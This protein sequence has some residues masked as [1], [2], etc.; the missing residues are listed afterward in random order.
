[1]FRIVLTLFLFRFFIMSSPIIGMF[2]AFMAESGLTPFGMAIVFAS[3]MVA[4]NLFEVPSSV[5]A[6]K[7]SRKMVIIWAIIV[8]MLSNVIFLFNQEQWAFIVH[9]I[10]AG[11]G[12]ALFSGTVEALLYD[13]LKAINKE[14]SYQKAYSFYHIAWSLGL[15]VSLFLSAFLV[16][17][18]YFIIVVWSLFSCFISLFFFIFGIKETKRAKEI[19][20]PHS[21][22]EIFLEGGRT[23]LY[24]KSVLYLG[25]ISL[26]FGAINC[27]FGDVAVI[28]SMEIGWAK[29]TMARIFGFNTIFEAIITFIFAKYAKKISVKSVHCTL[30]FVLLLAFIGMVF[31]QKWS[32]FMVFPL[33]WSD[34][35]KNMVV[36]AQIQNHVKSSSRATVTSCV[37][38]CFGVNY[39][40]TMLFL[41]IIATFYSFSL[42]FVIISFTGILQLILLFR[43]LK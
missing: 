34:R 19:D 21:F 25:L 22:K 43:M 9:M 1:M 3:F 37:S 35:L 20:A 14:N 31:H 13:E 28:T 12:V 42:G 15:C 8:L 40:I 24:N 26:L 17:F 7:Y 18:G 27:V 33:W 6:D 39:T 38:M 29:E 4:M 23:L 11:I 10:I 16:Q 30:I 5:I 2:S 41:G 36:D 32:I